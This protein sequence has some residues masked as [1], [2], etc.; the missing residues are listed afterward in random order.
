MRSKQAT[1]TR[2]FRNALIGCCALV[3]IASA[4]RPHALDTWAIEQLATLIALAALVWSAR[5]VQFSPL[6]QLGM[7]LLFCLHS[8]GTHYTY[9]LTPYDALLQ[10][11]FGGTMAEWFGWQ[12]NHYDRLVHLV[13]GLAMTLPFAQLLQQRLR[14]DHPVALILSANLVLS[15][16][17]LYEL[18]EWGAA[19]TVGADLGMAYLGTQGD[20]WDAHADIALAGLGS[21]VV[22]GIAWLAAVRGRAGVQRLLV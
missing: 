10:Q 19:R 8:I 1:Q 7:A 14:L 4:I 5:S 16:S 2:T 18:L 3:W 15:T 20:V 11:V 12:R 6:A 21:L 13:Y 17:A 9:S 22:M